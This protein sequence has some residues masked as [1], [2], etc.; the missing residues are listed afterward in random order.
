MSVIRVS[1][2]AAAI[3]FSGYPHAFQG[4]CL[5]KVDGRTYLNG[6]CKVDMFS[7]DGSFSIGA[8]QRWSRYFAYVNLDPNNPG[9]ASG[10]WNGIEGE[11]HARR[12]WESNPTGSCWTNR[13]AKICAW[14]FGTRPR[15][16]PG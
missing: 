4:D 14:R 9:L 13:R 1:F 12:T 6:P 16:L 8:D 3:L 11:S 15:T 5:L 7:G 10:S 2:T